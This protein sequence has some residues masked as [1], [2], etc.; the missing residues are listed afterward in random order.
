MKNLLN[1][2]FEEFVPRSLKA[3]PLIKPAL[4]SFCRFEV[5]SH[6][7]NRYYCYFRCRKIRVENSQ[8]TIDELVV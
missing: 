5:R 8:D 3:S 6:V 4:E 1:I 7:K 2:V